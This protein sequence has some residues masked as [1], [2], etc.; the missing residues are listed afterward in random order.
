MDHNGSYT[1]RTGEA[2]F[3]SRLGLAINY[4]RYLGMFIN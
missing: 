3:V 1:Q 4:I 2:I